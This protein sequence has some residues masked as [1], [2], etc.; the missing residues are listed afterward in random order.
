MRIDIISAVPELLSGPFNSSIIKKSVEKN[1]ADIYIH[2]LRDYSV[3]KYKSIDDYQYGGG[4]G[5]VMLIE[6][7]DKCISKLKKERNY[8]EIIYMSPDG[9]KLNQQTCN[10]LSCVKNIIILCGHYKGIDQRVRDN[11]ITMEISIGDYV[12]TGG[13]LP[14]AILTDGI[15]RLIPGVLGDETS[16]LTDS[17]QDNLLSHPI[18]SRPKEYNNW[19]VPEILLSG[20]QKEI[21]KWRTEQSVNLTK[22]KRPDLL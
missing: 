16:A 2:N 10:K 13:E 18:Y 7:I 17:F 9:M 12:L 15:I 4:A 5:M 20:H 1:L 19:P 22:K 8:D 6:P 3:N 14:A 21:E 11:L